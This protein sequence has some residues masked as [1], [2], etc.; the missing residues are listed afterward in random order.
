MGCAGRKPCGLVSRTTASEG[1]TALTLWWSS[2]FFIFTAKDEVI[3][4]GV[5]VA[6]SGFCGW[7]SGIALLLKGRYDPR[8]P[9]PECLPKNCLSYLLAAICES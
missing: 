1:G 5:L 6:L 7:L 2:F 8:P 3:N 4:S 9:N